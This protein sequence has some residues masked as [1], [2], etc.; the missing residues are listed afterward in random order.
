MIDKDDFLEQIEAS[1]LKPEEMKDYTIL[2][3][4]VD[5]TE[6]EKRNLNWKVFVDFVKPSNKIEVMKVQSNMNS[7]NDGTREEQSFILPF[8]PSS[9]L[10]DLEVKT[11]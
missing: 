2:P 7:N 3:D 10:T 6:S 4:T 11:I 9:R 1:E 8:V 5:P